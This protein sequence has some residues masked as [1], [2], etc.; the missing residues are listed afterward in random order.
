MCSC[1][2]NLERRLLPQRAEARNTDVSW[3]EFGA[4]ASLALMIFAGGV[5]FCWLVLW[6]Q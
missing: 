2:A 3:T 6:R 4:Y 1:R 5:G